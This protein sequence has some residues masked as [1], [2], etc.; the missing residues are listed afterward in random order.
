MTDLARTDEQ[1]AETNEQLRVV[2]EIMPQFIWIAAPDGTILYF[3]RPWID[4]TG[5]DLGAMQ[6]EGVK[7]VVHPDDLDLTWERWKDALVTGNPYEIEYRLR[8]A[9]TGTYRWFIARAVPYRDASGEIV[10]WIGT[11]TDIDA[12]K[13][14]SDRLR[15]LLDASTALNASLDVDAVCATLARIAIERIADWCF[16]VLKNGDGRYETR[17][18]AHRDQR[19]VAQ[20]ERLRNRYPVQ[21]GTPLD[22]AIRRNIPILAPT[23]NEHELAGAARDEE[24]L[25]ILESLQMRS[26]MLVPLATESGVVYG[27]MALASAES[28]RSYSA[29]DLEV[30][31]M[32]AHRAAAAIHTATAFERERMRSQRL[33]FIA[34]ASELLVQAADMQS[35]LDRLTEFIVTEMADLAYVVLVEDRETLRTVACAHADPL[36]VLIADRLRGRRTLRL[37]AEE[38]ALSMLAQHRTIMQNDLQMDAVLANM[39]EYLAPDVRALDI[40]S[41]ITTPLFSRGETLGALVVYWCSRDRT[42][43]E[44]DARVLTDVGRRLSIAIDH[45]RTMERERRIAAVLQQALLPQPGMLPVTP[46]LRFAANYQPS[47]QEL[48]VGGDWYDAL[49][50]TDGSIMVSVGDVCGRGLHAAGLMGKLRQAIGMAALYEQDPARILDAIDFQLRSRRSTAIVT[51]FVGIIDPARRSMRYAGAGHPPALLRREGEI[52]ELRSTGLPL[53]LREDERQESDDVDL[54]GSDLLVLYTDG[55]TEATH[56]VLFGEQRLAFLVASEAISCVRNP[57]AFLCEAILPPDAQ[58]DTAV[59]TVAF[60]EP[61]SWSFDAENAEAAHDARSELAAYL[62]ERAPNDADIA[63][64]ELVF[65]ELVGNVVRHAPGP[66]EVQVEWT[67]PKPVLHVIDR[68]HGFLR[69]P[70]LPAD[71]L[72]ENGR[73][74]YIV[75]RLTDTLRIERV[76]GYGNHV[77]AVLRL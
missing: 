73:G 38:K 13:R 72:C 56:D 36:K 62:R 6:H 8:N 60:G 76:A 40:R 65:G 44:E 54:R 4:Y 69:D 43:D 21:N 17:A 20:L 61:T 7:N 59:L 2:A 15:F 34:Q 24:F 19:R 51:A 1:L 30:A 68:G 45:Q 75:S 27:G 57:A 53:G 25:R 71:P 67:G 10:R 35:M 74:L 16:V 70:S 63:A 28:A 31:E 29:G 14:A 77:A 11:A 42:Y 50:L 22:R 32:V 33:H 3:N 39:W 47:S 64:A 41:A 48:E 9:S 12:Q 5:V 66:I 23:I 55:L 26:A 46:G 49:T 37:D 58:D 18:I 52:C